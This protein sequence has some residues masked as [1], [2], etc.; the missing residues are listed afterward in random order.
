[1]KAHTYRIALFQ[2]M[3]QKLITAGI[4]QEC[5][6]AL[7]IGCTAG[8]YSKIISDFG[9]RDVFGIDIRVKY[10]AKENHEFGSDLPGK[11]I[12]F[13]EMTAADLVAARVSRRRSNCLPRSIMG[14]STV[15]CKTQAAMVTAHV[16]R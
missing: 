7:D 6:S 9:F 8:F 2:R 16:T 11:R 10:V 3:V 15:I 4:I 14:C 5:G 13:E 12:T 1:M